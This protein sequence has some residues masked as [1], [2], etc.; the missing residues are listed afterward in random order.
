MMHFEVAPDLYAPSNN[1]APVTRTADLTAVLEELFVLLEDTV[2][3]GIRRN[4]MTAP[5][6]P[7][8]GARTDQLTVC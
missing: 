4:I 3:P 6:M 1:A 8:W 2:R 7:C 5:F